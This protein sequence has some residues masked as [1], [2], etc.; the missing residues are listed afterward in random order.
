MGCG[1][2]TVRLLLRLRS[3]SDWPLLVYDGQ[4]FCAL[5]PGS[6][7]LGHWCMWAISGSLEQNNLGHLFMELGYWG[8]GSGAA[9]GWEGKFRG[10]MWTH[11]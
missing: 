2:A 1:Q 10:V 8:L 9:Q 6:V 4:S 7:F 3:G 11:D 5:Q